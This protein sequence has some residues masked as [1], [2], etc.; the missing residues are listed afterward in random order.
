MLYAIGE[1]LL[2]VIGILIALSINNWNE[3][4]KSKE[5]EIKLLIELKS[6]LKETKEDLLSDI[7][8]SQQ[9]LSTTNAL[10]RSVVEGKISKNNPYKLATSYIL[11]TSL[12]FPKLSAYSAIQ[13]EGLTIISNV[14]LRKKITDFYQLHLKRVASAETYSEELNSKELKPYLNTF[15][16]YGSKCKDCKDLSELYKDDIGVHENLY[17]IAY[18]DDKFVHILKEKFVVLRTLNLRYLELS[19]TID[20]IIDIIDQDTNSRL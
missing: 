2:V 4:R 13:S 1:I 12:L 19:R 18:V 20:E 9:L 10:Y 15:S 14:E 17:L 11:E 5:K 8:K 7:T 6:D 16:S 3:N